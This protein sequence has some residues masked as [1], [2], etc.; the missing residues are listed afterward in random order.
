MIAKVKASI[1]AYDEKEL[2]EKVEDMMQLAVSLAR[3]GLHT[4]ANQSLAEA[5]VLIKQLETNIDAEYQFILTRD[6]F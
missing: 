2:S 3:G 6:F 4:K 1:Q 5:I